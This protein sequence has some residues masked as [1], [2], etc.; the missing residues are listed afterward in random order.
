MTGASL[1]AE[2]DVRFVQFPHPG[3]EHTA[4]PSGIRPWPL[5]SEPHRRTFMQSQATYRRAI[6]GGDQHGDVAFWGEWEG[7]AQLVTALEPTPRGP[8]WLCAP[9]PHGAPPPPDEEGTPPQNTDPFVWGDTMRYSAC[10]QPTNRKL[11][12]LGRGSLILFGSSVG[13]AFVLDTLLVVAGW[14]EHSRETFRHQLAGVTS[15]E[16]MRATLGPWHGWNTDQTF[17]LYV[18][19]TTANPVE[20]MYSFVPCQPA[21][22]ARGFPRPAIEIEGLIKPDLRMQT[23]SSEPLELSALQTLWRN[24]AGQ[25]LDDGLALATR[26]DLPG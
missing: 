18:G 8:S 13:G 21:A 22:G 17:R 16:H 5:G 4:G 7:E 11:R 19:A 2:G 24:T 23:G 25:V 26:L 14:A 20:D 3:P 10:R 6:D 15:E 12:N 9:N 1:R